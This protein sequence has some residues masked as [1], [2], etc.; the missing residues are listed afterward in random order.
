VPVNVPPETPEIGS[1]DPDQGTGSG[2]ARALSGH[3]PSKRRGEIPG[4]GDKE[5]PGP[6]RGKARAKAKGSPLEVE[7]VR[8]LSV[9]A[10]AAYLSVGAWTL[11]ALVWAGQ[12]PQVRLP[13]GGR[14]VLVDRADLDLL[15]LRSKVQEK[16][17]EPAP[18]RKRKQP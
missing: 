14:R 8:L 17:K 15:I 11:R 1:P 10:A 16:P 3:R 9:K 7:G 12:V 4:A 6:G 2:S 18:P 5:S 13:V